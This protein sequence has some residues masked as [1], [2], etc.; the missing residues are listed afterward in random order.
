[1]LPEEGRISLTFQRGYGTPPRSPSLSQVWPFCPK[2]ASKTSPSKI[3]LDRSQRTKS[4]S[5]QTSTTCFSLASASSQTLPVQM[6]P[7]AM[8]LLSSHRFLIPSWVGLRLP[9]SWYGVSDALRL[10]LRY[11][12]HHAIALATLTSK[13]HMKPEEWPILHF[14]FDSPLCAKAVDSVVP[15]ALMHFVS[16]PPAAPS[17]Q[18]AGLGSC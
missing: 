13:K 12:L 4:M 16:V 17:I 11:L 10:H 14:V 18:A 5:P 1:M 15:A 3:K 2:A 8:I 6:E 7:D 9:S